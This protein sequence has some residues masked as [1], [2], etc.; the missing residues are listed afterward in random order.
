MCIVLLLTV[1]F[2]VTFMFS[3][4]LMYNEEETMEDMHIP[5]LTNFTVTGKNFGS[6]FL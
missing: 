6:Q 4:N 5:H 2:F 3:D 1:S